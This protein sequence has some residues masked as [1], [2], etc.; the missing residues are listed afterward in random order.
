[1]SITVLVAPSG[2]K[3]SMDVE[4]VTGAISAGVKKAEPHARILRAPMVDGGEGFT[5]GIIAATGGYIRKTARDRP[6]RRTGR[7]LLWLHGRCR[8]T[9]GSH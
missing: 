7:R 5:R 1:M 6:C 9:D 8:Q 3:E 2:F 4:V